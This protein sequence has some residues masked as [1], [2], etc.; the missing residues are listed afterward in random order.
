MPFTRAYNI[1]YRDPQA[2]GLTEAEFYKLKELTG[3]DC[4]F[5]R[6]FDKLAHHRP[7]RVMHNLAAI[8]DT[9]DFLKCDT[10]H[11]PD[12]LAKYSPSYAKLYTEATLWL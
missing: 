8:L 9:I 3:H 6:T 1:T 10:S 4:I 5:C 7:T 2:R 12:I 11:V